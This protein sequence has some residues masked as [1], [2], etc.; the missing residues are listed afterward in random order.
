MNK[1]AADMKKK[2]LIS[3]QSATK[4]EGHWIPSHPLEV[5]QAFPQSKPW[6]QSHGAS[7]ILGRA[8]NLR[9][10]HCPSTWAP[11]VP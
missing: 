2:A 6:K 4:Q 10:M 7:F 5:Q 3:C 9:F 1:T 8:M 11:A